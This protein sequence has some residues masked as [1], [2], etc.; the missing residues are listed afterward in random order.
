MATRL[1]RVM[2]QPRIAAVVRLVDEKHIQTAAKKEKKKT[3]DS[4]L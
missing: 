4:K 2:L 3:H 1:Y